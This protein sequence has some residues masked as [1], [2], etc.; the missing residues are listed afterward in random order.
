MLPPLDMLGVLQTRHAWVL[1]SPVCKG[2]AHGALILKIQNDPDFAHFWERFLKIYQQ[3]YNSK[4]RGDKNIIKNIM[5]QLL[6]FEIYHT[7]FI[8]RTLFS[9]ILK[10]SEKKKC[11]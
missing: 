10:K 6:D 3:E 1:V 5:V 8:L 4:D 11:F 7:Y 2:L 9:K